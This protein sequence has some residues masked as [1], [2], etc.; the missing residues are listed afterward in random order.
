MNVPKRI[1]NVIRFC[2][3]TFSVTKKHIAVQMN[4]H[5]KLPTVSEHHPDIVAAAAPRHAA[6]PSPRLYTSPN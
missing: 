6:L 4:V 2:V 3:L 5:M 1:P